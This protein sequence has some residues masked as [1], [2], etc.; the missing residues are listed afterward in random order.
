MDV[1]FSLQLDARIFVM[2]MG[3]LLFT[4]V[5]VISFGV[6]SSTVQ[7]TVDSITHLFGLKRCVPMIP[8][9]MRIVAIRRTT[10]ATH[11]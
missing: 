5:S 2:V 10:A 7:D 11:P 1:S 4:I 3:S 9:Y 6:I 8:V